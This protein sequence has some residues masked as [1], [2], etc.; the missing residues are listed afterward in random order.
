MNVDKDMIALELKLLNEKVMNQMNFYN[1][2]VSYMAA[3]APIEVL[4]LPKSIES[5]LINQGFLRVYDIIDMDLTKIKGLGKTRIR[6]LTS[7]LN[8]FISI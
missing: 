1:K 7:C 4:C 2:T 8:Q 3:D 5:I 6:D